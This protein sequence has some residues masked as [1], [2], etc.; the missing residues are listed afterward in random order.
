MTENQLNTKRLD[1]N[2]LEIFPKRNRYRRENKSK[3][4]DERTSSELTRH[5]PTTKEQKR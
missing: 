3:R 1:T 5:F 4:E 2:D